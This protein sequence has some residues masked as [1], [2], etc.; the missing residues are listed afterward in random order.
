MLYKFECRLFYTFDTSKQNN[1]FNLVNIC[2]SSSKLQSLLKRSQTTK[3]EE[4]RIYCMCLYTY[5]KF[6]QMTINAQLY[7]NILKKVRYI[8]FI[9]F[10]LSVSSSICSSVA[11]FSFSCYSFIV[12]IQH[13][14]SQN[15]IF[16]VISICNYILKIYL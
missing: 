13:I 6:H 5:N 9:P 12:Q 7:P 11:L 1:V 8:L 14:S 2:S 4:K 16:G 15:M 3:I 10:R